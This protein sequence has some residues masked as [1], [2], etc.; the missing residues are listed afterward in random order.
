MKPIQKYLVGFTVLVLVVLIFIGLLGI[1][2]KK[3]SIKNSSVT[4]LVC[5]IL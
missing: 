3:V 4:M 5:G 1:L 2:V